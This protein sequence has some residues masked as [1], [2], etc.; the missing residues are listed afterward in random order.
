[1]HNVSMSSPDTEHERG[2][3]SGVYYEAK[4]PV[5]TTMSGT[6]NDVIHHLLLVTSE[7]SI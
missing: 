7:H 4:D 6:H 5:V 2:V 3:S 1:M